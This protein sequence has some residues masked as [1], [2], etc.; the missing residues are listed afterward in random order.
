MSLPINIHD[1]INGQSIEWERLEFKAGWNPE[2]ILHTVTA[3]A[4]DIN[5]WGGGYIVIGVEEN[6]GKPVLP[7]KGLHHELIDEIQKKL[8]ELCRMISPHYFPVVA[9][10][11]YKEKQILVVWCP[12]G[13]KRPYKAPKKLVKILN[14]N[15]S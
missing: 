2:T 13:N 9:P 1:L 4:N 5:N 12:G 15:I 14:R 11:T 6:N 8:L 10:V 3:F 7:P